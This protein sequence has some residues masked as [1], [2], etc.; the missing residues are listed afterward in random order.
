MIKG[1]NTNFKKLLESDSVINFKGL[2]KSNIP[3][4]F[5][6]V[7]YYAWVIVFTTWWTASPVTSNVFGTGLRNI[8]HS[9]NLISSAVFIFLIKKEWFYKTARIGAITI[10]TGMVIFLTTKNSY[11]GVITAVVIGIFLGIV[12]TSILMPFVFTLNNTEKLYAVVGSNLL[13]NIISLIQE[14]HINSAIYNKGNNILSIVILIIALSSTFFFK[15]DAI[16]Y[17]NVTQKTEIPSKVYLILFFNCAFAILCKGAGKGVLN[18]AASSSPFPILLWYYIGGLLGCIIYIAIYGFSK[19]S[20]HLA[21]N[22]CFGCLAM[23]LFL[24]AFAFQNEGLSVA[25][26]ILLGIGSTIGMINMYYILGVIGK[27]YNSMHYI[28]LSILFIGI[29]GGVFGVVVGNLINVIGTF[30]I[31]ITASIISAGVM[32]LFLILSPVLSQRHYDDEWV[33]DSEKVEINN[34]KNYIFRKYHLSNREI[35]VC[36]L[37]LQG[38]TLRQISAILSIAYPTVNTYCTSVYRKLGIN[39]RTE[40][41]ILFKDYSVK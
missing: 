24:N 36:R 29:C 14:T 30:K 7:V 41:L 16:P 2:Q 6:W 4:I 26:A 3:Y 25:F 8:L 23:G 21:W 34:D 17:D 13:I 12:N 22:I 1:I 27:K 40:L 9:I 39:S 18:I 38:Y 35:D 15:K 5:I 32:I 19:K 28:R 33:K 10:I 37:L 11:I 31:S 20:I